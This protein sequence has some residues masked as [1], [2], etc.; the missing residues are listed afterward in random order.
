VADVPESEFRRLGSAAGVDQFG[1]AQD[2]HW[3]AEGENIRPDA[4]P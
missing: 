1:G 4:E 2:R 3:I